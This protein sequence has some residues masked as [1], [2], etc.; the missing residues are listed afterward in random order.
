MSRQ[1]VAKALIIAVLAISTMVFLPW[2]YLTPV[3]YIIR[4]VIMTMTTCAL[5][6]TFSLKKCMSSRFLRLMLLAIVCMTV[7]FLFV[8]IRKSD[9]IQLVTAMVVLIIGM[10]LDWTEHDWAEVGYYYTLLIISV[11]ICNFFLCWRIIYSRVLYV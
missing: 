6:L 4:Y 2:I 1:K 8:P 9:I 3:Y 11:T 5:F 7:I 10:G